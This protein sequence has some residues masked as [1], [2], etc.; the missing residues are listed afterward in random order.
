MSTVPSENPSSR[1]TQREVQREDTRR[2]LLACARKLFRELGVEP[3]SME[4]IASEAGVSRA[5]V[6]LHFSG[7]GLLLRALLEADWA[8]Q[9][10]LFERFC[11]ADLA[12]RKPITEWVMQ[13]VEGMRVASDS[14]GI[15]RAAL[16]QN[17]ELAV[18]H[19]QHCTQLGT[20]LL[21]ASRAPS[22][23]RGYSASQLIEAQLVVAEIEY[24]ATSSAIAWNAREL[25][26]AVP[27]MVDRIHGFAAGVRGA[28]SAK[29][30]AAGR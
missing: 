16:G 28:Q 20:V 22:T 23:S 27:L 24:F 11:Q 8:S 18:L 17:A 26:I 2:R 1:P 6:Y 10:R 29:R 12:D 3:V 19:K 14:F 30:V 9:I 7:K 25:K 13:I 21:Q 15:Y 5:T 4:D